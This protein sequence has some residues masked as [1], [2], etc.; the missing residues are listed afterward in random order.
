MTQN[1]KKHLRHLTII[2]KLLS[3]IYKLLSIIYKL[4]PSLTGEGWGGAP[5]SPATALD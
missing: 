3:I 2:Y 4:T 5:T 1:T